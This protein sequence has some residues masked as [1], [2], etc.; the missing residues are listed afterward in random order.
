MQTAVRAPW[1]VVAALHLAMAAAPE[2][3]TRC[4]TANTTGGTFDRGTFRPASGCAFAVPTAAQTA[5][6]LRGVWSFTCGGSNAWVAYANLAR[7]LDPSVYPY[8][9]ERYDG[10]PKV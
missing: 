6:L 9:P 3:C 5:R 4:R 10:T 2:E 1:F 8:R 7:Q